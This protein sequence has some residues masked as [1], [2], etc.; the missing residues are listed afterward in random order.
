ML[1]SMRLSKFKL[2]FVSILSLLLNTTTPQIKEF[3]YADEDELESIYESC[4]PCFILIHNFKDSRSEELHWQF[5]RTI[6]LLLKANNLQIKIISFHGI[7]SP[8]MKKFLQ[9]DKPNSI[10]FI[11]F[12]LSLNLE[13]T[14]KRTPQVITAWVR[15]K[16]K[17]KFTH[18]KELR[19]MAHFVRIFKKKFTSSFKHESKQD[20]MYILHLPPLEGECAKHKAALERAQEVYEDFAK[21]RDKKYYFTHS[22]RLEKL[23]KVLLIREDEDEDMADIVDREINQKGV[24]SDWFSIEFWLK[25][26]T[27]LFKSV[28][29]LQEKYCLE[30]QD[31]HCPLY[32][33][34]LYNH[35]LD[36]ARDK[37]RLRV[38]PRERSEMNEVK[39]K[40][41]I[42]KDQFLDKENQLKVEIMDYLF[43]PDPR[44]SAK[45]DDLVRKKMFWSFFSGN[46]KPEENCQATLF[47]VFNMKKDLPNRILVNGLELSLDKSRVKEQ[48]SKFIL[49]ERRRLMTL[50]SSIYNNHFH[51]IIGRMNLMLF[52]FDSEEFD[53]RNRIYQ[54]FSDMIKNHER[55]Y[56][57]ILLDKRDF[58][59]YFV[60]KKFRIRDNEDLLF[61]RRNNTYSY[62]Q[63]FN[64][65]ENEYYFRKGRQ[66]DPAEMEGLK[67]EDGPG[68]Y[69]ERVLTEKEEESRIFKFNPEFQGF[70]LDIEDNLFEKE[71]YLSKGDQMITIKDNIEKGEA[72]IQ[73]EKTINLNK[74]DRRTQVIT[75]S[76]QVGGD[77]GKHGNA[78]LEHDFLEGK[79][80]PEKIKK[81]EM[82]ETPIPILIN[83]KNKYV[84]STFTSD[85]QQKEEQANGPPHQKWQ[86]RVII[87]S[88]TID[89]FITSILD[90]KIKKRFLN[91]NIPQKEKYN[92]NIR[93]VNAV[94]LEQLLNKFIGDS[95]V[96]L[97]TE[98]PSSL[99][100]QIENFINKQA[101]R[102]QGVQILKYW[103]ELVNWKNQSQQE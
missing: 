41:S 51:D 68:Y 81:I 7:L 100:L 42:R 38:D 14:G 10:R 13:Y 37:D 78:H 58:I 47:Q 3:W 82:L 87:T 90:G 24:F 88:Q 66:D 2:A 29:S 45:V 71:I 9:A 92:K 72:K 86:K 33:Q 64:Y 56:K 6:E 12:N 83:H 79:I 99:N 15:Q 30:S 95:I 46:Q 67:P 69:W 31:E 63:N 43:N 25:K 52:T 77:F 34:S 89:D 35:K 62:V 16:L 49:W 28:T 20:S 96:L 101:H 57:L 36:I 73:L 23:L 4:L 76:I 8:K 61:Q 65:L 27:T 94:D 1:S 19:D 17:D 97:H 54:I 93:K 74:I 22:G 84:N 26:L 53:N 60:R 80:D 44:F 75:Q 59:S 11:H 5:Q 21:V 70:D 18:Q 50:G 98:F 48:L 91:E 55:R 40:E 103:Q 32:A 102:L 85:K 39:Y